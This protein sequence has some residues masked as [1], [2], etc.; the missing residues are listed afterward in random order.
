[1]T[2]V[3]NKG[4]SI[5][6]TLP[7]GE[8]LLWGGTRR[9]VKLS[10]PV[11]AG[12]LFDPEKTNCPFHREDEESLAE[13]YDG[14]I[15]VLGNAFTPH[16]NHRLVIPRE[17]TDEEFVRTLGG[18]EFLTRCLKVISIVANESNEELS[19]GVHVLRGQN[20]PHLHWHVYGHWPAEQPHLE[21]ETEWAKPEEPEKPGGTFYPLVISKS[22]VLQLIARG[23]KTGQLMLV[24]REGKPI[25]LL[26]HYE[27]IA[28]MLDFLVRLTNMAFISAQGE[29][30]RYTVSG[31]C[32]TN[33]KLRYLLYTPEL[34]PIGCPDDL[35]DLNGTARARAWS[36]LETAEH[37]KEFFVENF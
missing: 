20:V 26:E 10:R 31:R 24:P 2:T 3:T 27:E 29:M 18:L 21:H 22:G 32:S 35:A 12:T 7:G 30:P 16:R 37:L 5:I 36:P 6:T 34:Q 8:K 11:E 19:L 25:S 1:M 14:T 23:P 28:G 17:C 4:N 33:G 13:Y 9:G 15:R